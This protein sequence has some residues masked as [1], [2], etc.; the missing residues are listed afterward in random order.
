[1]T[2]FKAAYVSGPAETDAAA[3]P[4]SPRRYQAMVVPYGPGYISPREIPAAG[5]APGG[6]A[7]GRANPA[8]AN[9]GD[10]RTG[11]FKTGRGRHGRR[12]GPA[13]PQESL[14]DRVVRQLAG[15]GQAA[16]PIWLPPLG[17]APALNALLPPLFITPRGCT[18][19]DERWRG[20]LQ[21][22]AGIV[23]RP[24]EQRR[25]AL[26]ADLS[27]AAGHVGVAGGPQSG[28]STMLRTL[29]CS[30]A[31][32]HTPDEVQFYCLDF[33]GGTVGAVA[34]LPHVGGVAT[35]Q[36]ADRVRRTRR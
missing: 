13:A 10:A 1:M 32:L 9:P 35:R 36:Q 21:A 26:W 31:L 5:A 34:G 20:R 29:I 14:L 30:L 25:D 8:E 18:T 15:Q 28:K 19:D 11:R 24:F 7:A 17:L 23:D 3:Q 27:G 4:P 6:Q 12:P 16:R 22:V 2:R 33:G